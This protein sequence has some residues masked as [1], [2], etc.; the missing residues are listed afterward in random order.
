MIPY[1]LKGLEKKI[2]A[3]SFR[4]PAIG[5]KPILY[6]NVFVVGFCPGVEVPLHTPHQLYAIDFLTNLLRML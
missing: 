2:F 6:P 5:V 1:I 4:T 3:T